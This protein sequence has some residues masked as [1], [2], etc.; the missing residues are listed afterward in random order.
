ML[1]CEGAELLHEEEVLHLLADPEQA[2]GGLVV[3][4]GHQGI[5]QVISSRDSRLEGHH[6]DV[7]VLLQRPAG[8]LEKA[9][10]AIDV[11][12]EGPLQ[13]DGLVFLIRCA[14]TARVSRRFVKEFGP[15][16]FLRSVTKKSTCPGS[17]ILE[18]GL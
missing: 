17:S 8:P 18:M 1:F 16:F 11:L 13:L 4:A 7:L 15:F 3:I 10:P 14:S 9:I 12:R 2:E 5:E 6:P